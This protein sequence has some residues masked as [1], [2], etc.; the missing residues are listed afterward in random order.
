MDVKELVSGTLKQIA[1]G[2]QGSGVSLN[3]PVVEI[4]VEFDVAAYPS[5]EGFEV[6]GPSSSQWSTRIKFAI[7]IKL[8]HR[9]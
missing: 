3:T 1:D 2:V 5:D 4:N 8:P 7:P 9:G 6:V